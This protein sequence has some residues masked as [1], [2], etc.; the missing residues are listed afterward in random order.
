MLKQFRQTAFIELDVLAVI[1]P[2]D[3]TL[4]VV[5]TINNTLAY[6]YICVFTISSSLQ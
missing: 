1:T 5:I 3:T 6:I 2:G 4:Y